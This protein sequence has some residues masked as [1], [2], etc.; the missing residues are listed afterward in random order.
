MHQRSS[1]SF[2]DMHLSSLPLPVPLSFSVEVEGCALCVLSEEVEVLAGIKG[3]EIP[4]LDQTTGC[5]RRG[6][7]IRD[8][9][10]AL[11]SDKVFI[12]PCHDSKFPLTRLRPARV[13]GIQE[14]VSLTLARGDTVSSGRQLCYGFASR[15]RQCLSTPCTCLPCTATR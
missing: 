4:L 15:R 5:L 14:A 13:Q 2:P 8:L 1:S 6:G 10:P 7:K 11:F 9:M 3:R 12:L